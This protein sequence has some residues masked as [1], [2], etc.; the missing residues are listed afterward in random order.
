MLAYLKGTGCDSKS[1]KLGPHIMPRLALTDR[2]VLGAKSDHT[3]QIDFFDAKTAGLALRV[4]KGGHKA[5]TFIFTVPDSGKR[6]RITLG[7]Y[8]ALS[9]AA[10]TKASEARGRL[11]E[12]GDPRAIKG[13]GTA[14]ITFAELVSRYLADPDKV[15]LRS[16]HEIRRRLHRDVLPIIGDI[17][18]AQLTKRDVKDVTDKIM[19]RG[20]RTQAWNTHKDIRAVLGWAVANDFLQHN[21]L[22]R[23]KPPG[24]FN[25]CER[26]LSDDE[27][28]TLWHVLPTALSG[29]KACQLIIKLCLITGQRLGEVSG[30]TRAEIDFARKLWSLPGARVKNAHAHSVPLSDSAVEIIREALADIDDDSQ[31]IFPS[32]D[33]GGLKSP[34]ITHAICRAQERIGLP[35]WSCHDLRRTCLDN[36]ARLGVP[37]H[38]IAHVANHRSLTK[39]SVTFLHYV[40]HS[41]EGEKRQAL[42][43]WAERL[44]AIVGDKKTASLVPM[45]RRKVVP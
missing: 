5:W 29:S 31:F 41:Y 36:L 30:M 14:E 22:D 7:S 43:L 6:K 28:F 45:R 37:P 3:P 33:G 20:A 9:L 35:L 25:V 16:I 18:L 34:R 42:D 13:R 38:T 17:R 23:V 10:R 32:K 26:V 19:K 4:T 1:K 24:G 2:F 27:I 11:Q 39:S 44:T 40:Q 12:S 15:R 8:P 21:P